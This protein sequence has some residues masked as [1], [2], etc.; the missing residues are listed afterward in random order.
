[1]RIAPGGGSAGRVQRAVSVVPVCH[2]RLLKPWPR[3]RCACLLA[4]TVCCRPLRLACSTTRG[5]PCA[6]AS[7]GSHWRNV[8]PAL[9][10]AAED[11]GRWQ[12]LLRSR[13][14]LAP[15]LWRQHW[16]SCR[17][18]SLTDPC[19]PS[20]AR[21]APTCLAPC[22]PPLHA[23]LPPAARHAHGLLSCFVHYLPLPPLVFFN[24]SPRS[25]LLPGRRHVPPQMHASCTSQQ[26][27]DS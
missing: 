10:Q 16:N 23:C 8:P 19:T 1:M 5:A 24:L 3:M 7:S 20:P 18:R 25:N 22:L 26:N 15:T 2:M 11:A 21:A 9:M 13:R 27:P 6:A 14:A 4:D 12:Q 17:T